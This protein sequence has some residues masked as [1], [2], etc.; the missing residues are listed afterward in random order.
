MMPVAEVAFNGRARNWMPVG[1]LLLLLVLVAGCARS[2][3]VLPSGA[4]S[5]WPRM[6]IVTAHPDDEASVGGAVYK[7]THELGGVVDLALITNGEGGYK[8]SLLAEPIYGLHLTD[9]A[10]GRRYLPQIRKNELQAGGRI[11]GIRN[12]FFFDQID[13]E[14][15]KDEKVVLQQVWDL[16]YV[17][18]RLHDILRNGSY[19]FV[20]CLL[21]TAETHGHHKAAT[22]LALRAVAELPQSLRPV[23]LGVSGTAEGEAR[24]DFH[25]L[26][27]YPESAVAADAPAFSFNRLMP[28]GFKGQ[29][30]YQIPV[31]WLIAEHKS[32]GTMQRYIAR[33]VTEEYYFFSQNREESRVQAARLFSKAA[34][35]SA[36]PCHSPTSTSFF[37][38]FL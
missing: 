11:I 8:Y 26:D 7:I 10:V 15:T 19:D 20:F 34:L 36:A 38:T 16:P 9:E 27:G 30:N 18:R 22:L 28:F 32:Q 3:F 4:A 2:T 37:C 25:G 33:G 24:L 35:A 23:I 1:I 13:H 14:Y 31:S 29:L 12:Y 21:P 5:A 17:T 6:L